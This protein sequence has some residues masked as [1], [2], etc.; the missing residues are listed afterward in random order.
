MD[1]FI[2]FLLGMLAFARILHV[3]VTLD[4]CRRR[5]QEDYLN[6]RPALFA[7]MDAAAMDREIRQF[8]RE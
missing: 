7:G 5:K 2:L 8:N 1:G 4:N 3:I 6:I